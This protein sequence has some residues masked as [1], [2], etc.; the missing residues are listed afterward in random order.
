MVPVTPLAICPVTPLKSRPCPNSGAASLRPLRAAWCSSHPRTALTVA[1]QL[2]PTS[3][4]LGIVGA[5]TDKSGSGPPRRKDRDAHGLPPLT[6]SP[7]EVLFR[8]DDMDAGCGQVDRAAAVGPRLAIG[9]PDV[10]NLAAAGDL[11]V[12]LGVDR[13]VVAAAV[14]DAPPGGAQPSSVGHRPVAV[15]AGVKAAGVVVDRGQVAAAQQHAAG[16]E[17]WGRWSPAGG[18]PRPCR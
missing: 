3:T 10:C 13:H 14:V 15:V 8:A 1:A 4:L 6:V 5:V 2:L 18:W 9:Q 16:D 11:R 17:R 7:R 12:A